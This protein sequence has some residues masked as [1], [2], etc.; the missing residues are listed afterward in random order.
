[1][2]S[3]FGWARMTYAALAVALVVAGCTRGGGPSETSY[4]SLTGGIARGPTS[5]ASRSGSA[6]PSPSPVVGA[7]LKI[8]DFHGKVI[9]NARTDGRG[10]YRVPLPAG[11]YRAERGAGFPGAA[12]NLP[13]IV[14]ISPGGQTRLDIW[15]D[16]GIRPPPGP[17]ATR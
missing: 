9:A 8:L 3:K 16:S 17:A 7:E 6:P 10:V 14:S 12:R 4:G 5:S 15:V 11:N 1:M 13:T 2:A